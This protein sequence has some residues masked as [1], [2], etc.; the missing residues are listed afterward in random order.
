[1]NQSTNQSIYL[2]INQSVSQIISQYVRWSVI[3]LDFN[4]NSW[5]GLSS[6]NPTNRYFPLNIK[7]QAS[8]MKNDLTRNLKE[9]GKAT[10]RRVSTTNKHNT[11]HL[12]HFAQTL[13]HTTH[14]TTSTTVQYTMHN[15]R[16]YRNAKYNTNR[17]TSDLATLHPTHTTHH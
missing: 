16:A 12:P 8:C 17:K 3:Y 4:Y 10:S 7:K 5:Q 2:S 15:I 11:T 6:P 13:P 1:M 9:N 14:T